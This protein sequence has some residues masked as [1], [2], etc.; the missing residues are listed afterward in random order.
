MWTF[1]FSNPQY[2]AYPKAFDMYTDLLNNRL[3]GETCYDYLLWWNAYAKT[4]EN[5]YRKANNYAHSYFR[6]MNRSFSPV[7][8][9]HTFNALVIAA[10]EVKDKYSDKWELIVVSWIGLFKSY[11]HWGSH[12]MCVCVRRTCWSRW[13]NRRWSPTCWHLTPCWRYCVGAAHWPER[14]PSQSSMRWRPSGS[15]GLSHTHTRTL[16]FFYFFLR[17]ERPVRFEATGRLQ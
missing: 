2:G 16:L 17:D 8:D 6:S 13:L 5:K 9:V 11:T 14:R 3:T 7:A 12:H 4:P 15:V 10:A 1:L